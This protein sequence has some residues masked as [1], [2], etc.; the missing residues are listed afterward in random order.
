MGPPWVWLVEL[1][2]VADPALVW[3]AVAAA[4]GVREQQGGPPLSLA[5]VRLAAGRYAPVRIASARD[6]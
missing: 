3:A 5:L 4:L 1:A 6:A 2:P